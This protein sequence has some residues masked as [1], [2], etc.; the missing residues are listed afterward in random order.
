MAASFAYFPRGTIHVAVVDPTVGTERRALCVEAGD[1]VFVGPDNGVLSIACKRAGQRKIVAIEEKKYFLS[2]RSRTFHGRDV[3]AP[4]AAHISAGVSIDA[5]GPRVRSMKRILHSLPRIPTSGRIEG[6]IVHV[7]SFGNLI[8]NIDEETIR[9]VFP[10]INKRGLVIHCGGRS[11]HGLSDAYGEAKRGQALA[12]IGSY[13]LMELAVRD[14][15]AS[16]TLG[17]KRGGAVTVERLRHR[18]AHIQRRR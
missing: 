6:E 17:T 1:Y 14:G 15:S 7:D 18:I 11:I 4:V 5:F 12:L 10:R 3:F 8:T 13:G 9:K 2:D 16:V